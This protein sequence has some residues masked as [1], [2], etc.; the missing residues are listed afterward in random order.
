[1]YVSSFYRY[2]QS[3]KGGAEM[4]VLTRA[5]KL[6]LLLCGFQLAQL[7]VPYRPP[8]IPQKA[9]SRLIPTPH[10]WPAEDPVL[11]FRLPGG[12]QVCSDRPFCRSLGNGQAATLIQSN[13]LLKT[14]RYRDKMCV[15]Y[16]CVVPVPF[17][18]LLKAFL[19]YCGLQNRTHANKC[20]IISV[21]EF[22]RAH[23]CR[24]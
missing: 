2:A 10:P 22:C 15:C 6:C 24:Q 16:C 3:F 7:I 11:L 1:M 12:W 5:C 18:R 19:R 14:C 23:S 8:W 13:F 17:Q 9:V 20:G 21:G 4:E